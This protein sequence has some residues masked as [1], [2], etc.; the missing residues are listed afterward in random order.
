[1]LGT[2]LPQAV[3]SVARSRAHLKHAR[4]L[5][6]DLIELLVA[7]LHETVAHLAHR[8]VLLGGGDLQRALLRL[9][10]RQ[11]RLRRQGGGRYRKARYV[12]RRRSRRC[13]ARQVG[14]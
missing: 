6:V 1:V 12:A 14:E 10:A 3:G 9:R 13:G 8:L 2:L 5:G 4:K 11:V 7:L